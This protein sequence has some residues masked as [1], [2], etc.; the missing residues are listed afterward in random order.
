MISGV[1]WRPARSAAGSVDGK[2]LKMTN[3]TA[4]TMISSR[5]MPRT[6]RMM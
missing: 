2:R 6:R 1:G 3:V 5:N 4:L